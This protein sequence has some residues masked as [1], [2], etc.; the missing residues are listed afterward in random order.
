MSMAKKT[1]IAAPYVYFVDPLNAEIIMEFV[2]GRNGK[3]VITPALCRKIG[4]YSAQLHSN[5]IVHG[6]LTTSNFIVD[7]NRL[8]LL[9]FGLAYYSER[10]EDAATDLRLIKEVFSSA[11]ARVKGA[12]EYFVEG[13]ASIAGKKKTSRI[14]ENVREIEQRGRY[15]RVT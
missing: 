12:F 11:H 15:A 7:K 1:G 6:D 2:E 3:D 4:S 14:L 5:N 13:Y 8:V 10:T 9:D